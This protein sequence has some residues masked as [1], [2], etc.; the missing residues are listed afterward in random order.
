MYTLTPNDDVHYFALNLKCW[1]IIRNQKKM[2]CQVSTYKK[3][4]VTL[5]HNE[6]HSELHVA[7]SEQREG[8]VEGMTSLWIQEGTL[9]SF[10]PIESEKKNMSILRMNSHCV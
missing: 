5:V 10:L 2:C 1:H 6:K 8:D 9:A 3:I 4:G 7:G